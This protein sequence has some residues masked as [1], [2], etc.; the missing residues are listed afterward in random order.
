[1]LTRG[2]CL[3]AK[4][5]L[6][7]PEYNSLAVAYGRKETSGHLETDAMFGCVQFRQVVQ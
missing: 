7:M 6:E 1:M 5:S 2:E 3:L 4:S